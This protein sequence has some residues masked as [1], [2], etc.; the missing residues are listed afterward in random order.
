MEDGETGME[1]EEKRKQGCNIAPLQENRKEARREN[2]EDKGL[3]RLFPVC[4]G[5]LLKVLKQE[6]DMIK[7]EFKE[8]KSGSLLFRKCLSV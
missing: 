1:R 5:K 8:D 7:A 3:E 4:N 6:N 2:T